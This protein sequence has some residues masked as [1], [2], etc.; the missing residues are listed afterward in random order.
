M[1]GEAV[2]LLAASA[3]DLLAAI[4][5]VIA[6][7]AVLLQVLSKDGAITALAEH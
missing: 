1:F 3:P 7:A 5:V 2:F 6:V 4:A